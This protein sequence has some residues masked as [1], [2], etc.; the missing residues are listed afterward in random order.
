MIEIEKEGKKWKEKK[1]SVTLVRT[2][3]FPIMTKKSVLYFLDDHDITDF[4]EQF[5]RVSKKNILYR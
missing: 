3:N 4:T 2:K 5:P 1:S